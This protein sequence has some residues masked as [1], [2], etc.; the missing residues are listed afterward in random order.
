MTARP[1]AIAE[2]LSEL[3]ANVL[4]PLVLGGPLHLVR[5]FGV[6][7]ALLLGDGAPAIDRDLASRIEL[8]R[9]RVA[10][11][12]APIDT[13]PELTSADW[14]LLCALNDLLQL[15]NHELAGPLTRSRYPRLLASVR[16]LCELVPAPPDVA[17]ALSRHATFARVLDCFRTDAQVVWWT[18]SASFRGQP[19]PPR[20]LR[21]RQLRNV[22][23]STR[24]V[25]LAE[26]AQGIPGLAAPDYAD[27]LALW[28]T[29]TPLTDL[30]TATRKSPPFAWSASTL[31][32]VATVPGRS[33]AYRALLRQPHDLAV[34]ALARAAREVPPRFGQARVLAESFA[35]EVAAGIKLLDERSGAA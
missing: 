8:A 7:L 25:G 17:T 24:R 30:A 18:G 32:I 19:P 29:R 26:M 13:L 4:A 22:T 10:R 31:A 11:L 1:E 14:A 35:S 27:A 2:R 16:D 28:L 12:I 34:A 15:T 21:W 6:R 20:L 23:V 33:L 5:P 9:V 3:A